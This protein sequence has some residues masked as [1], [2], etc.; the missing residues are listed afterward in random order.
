[1]ALLDYNKY[2]F[3]ATDVWSDPTM[4]PNGDGVPIFA[5]HWGQINVL[6]TDGSVQ[7][8]LPEELDPAR[9]DIFSKY[10]TQ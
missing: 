2:L 10:W 5:R 4:D 7:L 6:M 8:M 1:V 3:H 9:P